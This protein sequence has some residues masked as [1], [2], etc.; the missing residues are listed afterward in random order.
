MSEPSKP[1]AATPRETGAWEQCTFLICAR[2]HR[3]QQPTNC[4]AGVVPLNPEYQPLY[5]AGRRLRDD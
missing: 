4:L 3:C 1:A 2:A 5:R